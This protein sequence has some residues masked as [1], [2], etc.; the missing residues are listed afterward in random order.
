ML[1]EAVLI[2][3]TDGRSF[4][5]EG[6][7]DG[8]VD[9]VP[10]KCCTYLE[11]PLA[12]QL[13]DD[14]R[15]WVELHPTLSVVGQSIHIDVACSALHEGKCELFGKEERPQMCVRFPEQPDQVIAGC[16]YTLK[17]VA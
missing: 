7:C 16:S 6:A 11:L 4:I 10:G 12:R 15:R 3:H 8:C 1:H 17:E 14:E 13:S 5:R 9:S 2:S